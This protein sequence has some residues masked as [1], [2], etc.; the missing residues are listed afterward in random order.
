[1]KIN[2]CIYLGIWPSTFV[3]KVNL[4]LLGLPFNGSS[5]HNP[6]CGNGGQCNDDN[7]EDYSK[8]NSI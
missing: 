2:V 3:C 6:S 4:A 5:G 8:S 7:N 1:M